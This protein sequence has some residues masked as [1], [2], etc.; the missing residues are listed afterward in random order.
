MGSFAVLVNPLGFAQFG[1]IVNVE[2]GVRPNSY[3]YLQLRL[4]ALGVLTYVVGE[5]EEV[6]LSSIGIGGGLRYFVPSNDPG[7]WYV[8][9][10]IEYYS[11]SGKGDVGESYEWEGN[12]S[13][14]IFGVNT[15]YRWR[16]LGFFVNVGLMG[17][18][19]AGLSGEWHYTDVSYYD[20]GE[21]DDA[22]SQPYGMLEVSIGWEI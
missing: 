3:L 11:E 14:F 20:D 10:G 8:G 4:S 21:S 9:G 19:A 22:G 12:Y 2:I 15:G 7:R 16:F 17:G 6:S 5:Y 13:Y 18:Y 1:P